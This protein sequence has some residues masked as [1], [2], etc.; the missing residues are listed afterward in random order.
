MVVQV[1][2]V[3]RVSAIAHPNIALIKYWG[4]RAS[5]LNL[6]AVGSLSITLDTLRTQ[7]HVG[8]IDADCDAFFLDDAPADAAQAARLTRFVDRLRLLA[9]TTRR[10]EVH[11]ENNF[12]TGAGLASSASGFAAL[13]L[14]CA[15]ALGLDL[16]ARAL[17]R[18]ARQGSGSAARSVFGGFV[19]LH[20]GTAD[21]GEDCY[22]ESLLGT[23]DWPLAVAVAVVS[24]VPKAV[25]STAG[26]ESTRL[27]S[28]YYQAWCEGSETDLQAAQAAIAARDFDRLAALS[29]HSCLKMH[30][31]MLAAAPALMYWHP[32]TVAL[33]QAVRHL[34]AAGVPV[35]FT[36]DA[37]PQLKAVCLPEALPQV[38]QV[39]RDV[40]GVKDVFCCGLGEGARLVAGPR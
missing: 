29:E 1:P 35:F 36:I 11:S 7:T 8:L 20:R 14:A 31:V 4:K 34:R 2:R 37:G 10:V 13:S 23:A 12:P 17:S 32:A 24:R 38:V 18:W 16:D 33:M 19:L 5:E 30:A 3:G 40:P 9:G 25:G 6:P 27:T 39:L 15:H 21:D 28:P 26:M 22:A